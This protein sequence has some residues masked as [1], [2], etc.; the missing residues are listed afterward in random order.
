MDDEYILSGLCDERYEE[1]KSKV[2]DLFET[3]NLCSLPINAFEIAAKLNF[4]TV[5][6]KAWPDRAE[7][8]A[9]K[10]KDGVS[11]LCDD[12]ET[13]IL[14][15]DTKTF[16]R[17][18]WTIMHEI[19]HRVL[20]HKEESIVAEREAEFFAKYALI[21]PPL[22]NMLGLKSPDEIQKYFIASR[23]AALYGLTIIRNGCATIPLHSHKQKRGFFASS[24]P[25]KERSKMTS[26]F[27]IK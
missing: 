16:E 3:I 7:K 19:A 13:Y 10:Q 2:A 21:P 23:E 8:L 27:H 25:P 11:F 20:G 6:Y 26:N 17:Q 1:L 14:Y 5:P 18:N 15:N 22:V 9:K 4:H 12:G 24:R